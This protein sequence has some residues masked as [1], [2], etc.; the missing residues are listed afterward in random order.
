MLSKKLFGHINGEEVFLFHMSKG[1]VDVEV[2]NYG[3]TIISIFTPNVLGVKSNIVAGFDNLSQYEMAHP[4]LG[5]IVGRYTNRVAKGR[6]TIDDKTWQLTLNDGVNHLHGGHS[7]FNRKLWKIEETIEEEDRCGVT[8]SYVSKD[9]EEGYPG[10]LELSV[11]YLLTKENRL[12]M[13]YNATTDRPTIISLTNHSYFNL[14]GFDQETIHDHYLQINADKYTVKNEYNTPSGD[15]ASITETPFDF[16]SPQKIGRYIHSLKTDMGYDHNFVLNNDHCTPDVAASLFEPAS[17]RIL[18][19][20]TNMPGMQVYTANWWDGTF[21]GYQGKPYLKHGAVALE[22]Q[23]F[24]DAPNQ[25]G[26][27]SAVLRPGELYS[28]QTAFQFLV[29]NKWPQTNKLNS[30][31]T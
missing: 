13:Q 10:N 14:S 16:S 17:G 24:P 1:E 19:V 30:F 27:P 21:T 11:S 4:Y 25:P 2:M 18:K 15:M 6:F 28:K 9:G 23:A 7:G 12:I 5:C 20:Y 8:F 3:C 22:T 26:F 31:I 29:E